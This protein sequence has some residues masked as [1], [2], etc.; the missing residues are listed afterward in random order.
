VSVILLSICEQQSIG[1]FQHECHLE[2]RIGVLEQ[3]LEVC[4]IPST[5]LWSWLVGCCRVPS[6]AN[7]FDLMGIM[8]TPPPPVEKGDGRR[9]EGKFGSEKMG[10][11]T[12][13][14][15]CRRK[16]RSGSRWCR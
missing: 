1:C 3:H 13:H 11:M 15:A 10:C 6:L 12:Y 8:Q 4:L 5:S 14:Q 9:K 16:S 2:S 7:G